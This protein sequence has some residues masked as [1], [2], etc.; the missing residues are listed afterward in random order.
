MSTD[1][2][3]DNATVFGETRMLRTTG[4]S[5]SDRQEVAIT[6][7]MAR[8][9]RWRDIIL[10]I[11]DTSVAAERSNGSEFTRAVEMP[12]Y[13]MLVSEDGARNHVVPPHPTSVAIRG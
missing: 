7:R 4:E 10:I 9:V 3:P 13:L 6:L 8:T 12:R 1:W 11:P 2:P 5:V